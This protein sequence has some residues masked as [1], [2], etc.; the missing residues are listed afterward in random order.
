MFENNIEF[1]A[2]QEYIKIIDKSL[3]PQPALK[4]IPQWYKKLSNDPVKQ[5]IKHCMPFLDTLTTGYILKMPYDLQIKHNIENTQTQQKDTFQKTNQHVWADTVRKYN[6]NFP[7]SPQ[8]HPPQQLEGSPLTEKNKNLAFHK[9]INPWKIQTPKGYSCL[10]VPP[11]N[12]ADD[13]FSIIP[14]I[15]DTDA[16]IIE[17]NF[18]FVVN[19]DKYPELE[20]IIKLGTSYVQVIPFKRESW[21]MSVKPVSNKE[22][23]KNRFNFF[24]TIREFYKK[25]NWNKKIFK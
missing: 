2:S 9:I 6:I 20:T 19:S 8:F 11:L 17:I 12:N 18:P 13:R 7:T 1:V 10:F 21:K 5:T 4:N 23:E 15:V 3:H 22:P 24:S 14:G 25:N 16:H